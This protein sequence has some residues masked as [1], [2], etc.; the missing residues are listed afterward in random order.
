MYKLEDLNQK[1]ESELQSIAK[2]LELKKTNS[3]DKES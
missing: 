1:E 3:M 2:S